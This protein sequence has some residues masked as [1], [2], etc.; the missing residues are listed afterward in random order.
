MKSGANMPS[1]LRERKDPFDELSSNSSIEDNGTPRGHWTVTPATP[2]SK[3]VN[4]PLIRNTPITEK[5]PL[6][7]T[8]AKK[9]MTP[10]AHLQRGEETDDE[11]VLSMKNT[12]KQPKQNVAAASSAE[13]KQTS[14]IVISPV[15]PA[16]P[17][18]TDAAKKESVF[19]RLY[20]GAFTAKPIH[21]KR[22]PQRIF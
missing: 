18:A 11:I 5:T 14:H 10:T 22:Y 19:D 9:T 13:K 15:K 12:P 16:T 21:E 4:T 3:R 20:K 17:K 7:K 6:T 2:L 8:S 1:P